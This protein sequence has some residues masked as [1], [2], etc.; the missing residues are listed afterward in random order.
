MGLSN[1]SK[2]LNQPIFSVGDDVVYPAHG[3][4]K[5]TGEEKEIIAGM[6]MNLYVITFASDKMTLRVPK[7]RAL[8]TGL[9]HLSSSSDFDSMIKILRGKAKSSKGMWSK[10][11]QEYENKINSGSVTAIAEVLRDL[12]KNVDDPNRSYS[13][14]T[15]YDAALDRLANEYSAASSLDKAIASEKIVEILNIAKEEYSIA[16]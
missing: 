1:M 16:V 14:R 9:R 2:M 12:H 8:K 4:G 6:D 5:I 13:E 7:S 10:R 15:I 3:V 11:A